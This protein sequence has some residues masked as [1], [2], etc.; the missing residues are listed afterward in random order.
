MKYSKR[1]PREPLTPFERALV[2]IY[3]GFLV[4][5]FVVTTTLPMACK[6]TLP[7]VINLPTQVLTH[8]KPC[9][10]PPLKL[11]AVFRVTTGACP[12]DFVCYDHENSVA[13][14]NR[15]ALMRDWILAARARCGTPT[16]DAGSGSK[17]PAT[18]EAG[19]HTD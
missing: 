8:E 15:L 5:C 4:G 18:P 2:A 10:L 16:A 17:P 14:A 3:I 11:P 19:V 13:L 7:P 1:E 9:I 6:T 12:P